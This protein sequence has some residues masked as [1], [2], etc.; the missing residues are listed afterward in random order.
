MLHSP[1][2][3]HILDPFKRAARLLTDIEKKDLISYA[4]FALKNM[5]TISVDDWLSI[6]LG[7]REDDIICI[8]HHHTDVYRLVVGRK[9]LL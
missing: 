7:A 3:F 4:Y 8:K 9:P 6:Q 1:H 5:H 2:N